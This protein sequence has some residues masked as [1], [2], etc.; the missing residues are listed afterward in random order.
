MSVAR[1]RT[2]NNEMLRRS[3]VG[4][5]IWLASVLAITCE[6]SAQTEWQGPNQMDRTAAGGVPMVLEVA[7]AESAPLTGN[8][9]VTAPFLGQRVQIP[10]AGARESENMK[11]EGGNGMVTLFARDA[12]LKDIL[13]L[14]AEQESLNVVCT[15]SSETKVSITLHRVPLDDAIDALASVAGCTWT[16]H[17]NIVH[18]FSL[19]D[20]ENLPPELQGRQVQVFQLNYTVAEDVDA[21]VKGML[22]SVGNSFTIASDPADNRKAKDKI[23]VEDLPAFL[24]RIQQYIR[25]IDIPP[26]QVLIEVHVL[27]VD[28]KDGQNHGVNF[29]HLA[30][31][32]SHRLSLGWQGFADPL[33]PQAAVLN[34]AGGDTEALIQFLKSTTD[35]KTLASPKVLVV[36]GQEAR[37]QVGEKLPYRLTTT[38]QTSTQESVNFLETGIVLSVTPRIGPNGQILLQARPEV[39]TG[40]VNKTTGLPQSETS[41]V[42]TD[43]LLQNGQGMVIGGLIQEKDRNTQSKVTHL[44]DIHLL[45]QLFRSRELEKKRSEIVFVL[46]PH[47]LPYPQEYEEANQFD[48]MRATTPLV[49]GPLERYPRP[50]EAS[51]PDAISNPCYCVRPRLR[52]PIVR[53]DSY[54]STYFEQYQGPDIAPLTPE[55]TNP[56]LA[57]PDPPTPEPFPGSVELGEETERGVRPAVHY[58]QRPR[59]AGFRR[60]PPVDREVPPATRAQEGYWRLRP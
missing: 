35:A 45:G 14:I 21:I 37:F 18:V 6:T 47:V 13:A 32:G 41:N 30:K 1:V 9:E 57:A 10:V 7:E 12:L 25:Q 29:D 17:K 52:G 39:S 5:G 50:W 60:L 24:D 56:E 4:L 20:A 2:A 49:H 36:D 40:E 33:A 22:S 11:V 15:T 42:E 3:V 58:Q 43:V 34:L 23:V 55:P 48:V 27:E 54:N 8:F 38:S 59:A 26:R 19:A 16:R 51:L 44:A 53:N 28:L 46:V 31:F